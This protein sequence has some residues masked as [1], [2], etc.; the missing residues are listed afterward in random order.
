MKRRF[1]SSLHENRNAGPGTNVE[2]NYK[3]QSPHGKATM[4]KL[5]KTTAVA[6]I[7]SIDTAQLIVLNMN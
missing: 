6:I 5:N 7:L 3:V 4:A 1:N 2:P